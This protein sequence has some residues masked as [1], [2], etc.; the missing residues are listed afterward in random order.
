M[1]QTTPV[2]RTWYSR[3]QRIDRRIIYAA[4]AGVVIWQ[5]LFPIRLEMIV[6][7]PAQRL[8]EA[9]E[10]VPRDKI[11]VISADWDAGTRGENAPQ[12]EAIMRHLMRRGQRF[13][14][15]NLSSPQGVQ[16]AQDI[17]DRVGKDYHKEYGVD[18]VNWGYKAGGATF[19]IGW[20]KDA[21][22]LIGKDIKGTAIG[23]VPMMRDVRKIGDIGMVVDVTGSAGLLDWW[24]GQVQGIYGTPFGMAVTGIMGPESYPYLDSGQLEGLLIGLKGAAEYEKLINR[25]GLGTA[26]MPAQSFAHLF[27]LVLI[28][29]GNIGY[30]GQR[31]SSARAT[32]LARL[33][34]T[35]APVEE[36]RS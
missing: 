8:Y 33:A 34:P 10:A 18:W 29:L 16:L 31:R 11:V 2:D 4:L 7:P 28:V 1:Q 30:I 15:L 12:T 13:A 27:I 35:P 9:F 36:P 5:L 23:Q 25:P 3:L 6:S 24:V 17:A 26:Q 32:R 14:I 22:R 21:H 19:L 20:A